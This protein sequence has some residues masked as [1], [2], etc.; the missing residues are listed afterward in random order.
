MN[1]L[2]AIF[3]FHRLSRL[4]DCLAVALAVSLPLSTS[5]TGILA[6]LWLLAVAP[7][8]DVA[9]VRRELATAAGGL[10]VL[11]WALAAAGM[12]WADVP[13]AERLDGLNAYHKLLFILLFLAQFRRSERGAWVMIGFLLSCVALLVLSWIL[14]LLPTSLWPV[15]EFAIPVKDRIAQATLF[16]ACIFSCWMSRSISGA[17]AGAA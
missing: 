14:W 7:T 16:V 6:V 3:P 11:L 15:R 8:L 5:A 17:T 1:K 4:A 10:P 9:T 12:F 2:A 13:W